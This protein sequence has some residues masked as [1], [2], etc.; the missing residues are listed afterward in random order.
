MTRLLVTG[1][2]GLLGQK[3]STLVLKQ[4][5]DQITLLA[6]ARGSNRLP[7][8]ASKDYKSLDFTDKSQV[9]KC[10]KA[11]HPDVVIHAG[12]ATNVDW[13]EDHQQACDLT[14]IQGTKNIAQ[15]CSEHNAHMV[16]ISTDFIFD[17]SKPIGELYKEDEAANPLSYYGLSKLKAEQVVQN[18]CSAH[19]ILRTV[20]VYG[21][22]HDMSRSNVVLW[23]KSKLEKNESISVVDD[24][25]R[26]PTLAEDL[27]QGS[28][29]AALKQ[30]KGIFNISGKDY[31]N[32][33]EL[34]QRVADFYNL[35][36]N[37]IKPCSSEKLNQTAKRPPRTGF[38]LSKS[39]TQLNYQPMSFEQ[40]LELLT[41]QLSDFS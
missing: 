40:G 8:L 25:Y 4:Y 32:I 30:E 10:F 38:D 35:D 11:F 29:L 26:T 22:V 18:I 39:K 1:S 27:A 41:K 2:N 21:I 23:V 15:A 34:A 13:C 20:L 14:N 6:T 31:M 16:H 24:Q 36:R 7:N 5:T 33:F 28:I 12:A 19:S 3:I 37:L 17:G 9:D